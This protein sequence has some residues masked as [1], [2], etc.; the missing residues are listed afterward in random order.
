MAR[1]EDNKEPCNPDQLLKKT[2]IVNENSE[3]ADDA[4]FSSES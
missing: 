1:T 3:D 2:L 4:A